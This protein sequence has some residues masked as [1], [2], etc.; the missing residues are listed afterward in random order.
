MNDRPLYYILKDKKIVPVNDVMEWSYHYENR[1]KNRRVGYKICLDG[2][3]ISTV[4]LGIDHS[5][6]GEE[7]PVLFETMVFPYPCEIARLLSKEDNWDR[8]MQRYEIWDQAEKGHLEMVKKYRV[9][10]P[11]KIIVYLFYPYI[12]I[13]AIFGYYRF[14]FFLFQIKK[15]FK[16]KRSYIGPIIKRKVFSRLRKVK[17]LVH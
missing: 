12:P 5:M 11:I 8:E 9:R 10:H 4:F 1:R 6:M 17:D 2:T 14:Q 15:F 16:K 13:M 3:T 7:L